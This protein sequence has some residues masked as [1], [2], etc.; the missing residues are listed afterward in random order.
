MDGITPQIRAQ[1]HWR[2]NLSEPWEVTL[3][4]HEFGCTEPEL[5]EAVL[6]A[7]PR[8]GDVRARIAPGQGQQR[9]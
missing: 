3:W 6:A 2:I 7:G 8:A 1:D 4:T 9:K 5:R